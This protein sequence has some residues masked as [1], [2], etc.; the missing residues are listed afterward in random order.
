MIHLVIPDPHACPG[1]SNKRAEWIGKI[2]YDLRPDKVIV[3]G[4][5][6]DMPSLSSYDKGR[7][8]FEGR[9]YYKDIEAHADFQDRMWHF[10]KKNKK[11]R[12]HAIT[13]IGNHEQRIVKAS[14]LSPELEGTITLDDL[15]LPYWYDVIVEY[16]GSTPGSI[17]V[18]GIMYAHYLVSGVLGRPIG[19]ENHATSLLNKK[20][21]SCTVG[22]THTLDYSVRTRADGKKIMGLVAGCMQTNHPSFAGK[23]S[24]LWWN[25]VIIKSNVSDGVYDLSTVRYNG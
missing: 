8:A 13:L 18:D 7:K 5:T 10:Y 1:V 2:M 14:E 25:G 22:H 16:D 4:D 11:K 21:V 9:R 23:A 6:A 19:G 17:Q 20:F 24:D 3:L 15:D 12:P